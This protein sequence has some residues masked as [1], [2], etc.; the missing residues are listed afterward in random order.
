MLNL[1]ELRKKNRFSIDLILPNSSM[2]IQ[3]NQL[4][5]LNNIVTE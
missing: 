2:K 3:Q 1:P 5:F 4:N